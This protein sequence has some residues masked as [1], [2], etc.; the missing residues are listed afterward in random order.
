M[1]MYAISAVYRDQLHLA[2]SKDS[3]SPYR[4]VFYRTCEMCVMQFTD[5]DR[6]HWQKVESLIYSSVA[7]DA[8]LNPKH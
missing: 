8:R 5:S 1:N 4:T 3:E 6:K 2:H 7:K